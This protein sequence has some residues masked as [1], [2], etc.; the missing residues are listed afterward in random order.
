LSATEE[1]L[2]PNISIFFPSD[3]RKTA[4]NKKCPDIPVLPSYELPP[5]P[6]FWEFFPKSNLPVEISTPINVPELENITVYLTPHPTQDQKERAGLL[7]SELRS[8]S[9]APIMEE[10]PAISGF[11]YSL[12][13]FTWRRIH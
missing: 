3:A 2:N 8:G 1:W 13:N 6:G 7:I 9:P 11:E 5:D 4:G 12:S 10:L